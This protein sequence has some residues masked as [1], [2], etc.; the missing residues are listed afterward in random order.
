L[1]RDHA[2]RLG[3]RHRSQQHLRTATRATLAARTAATLPRD[4]LAR[5]PLGSQGTPAHA[6]IGL[7]HLDRVAE[8]PGDPARDLI[9]A[10]PPWMIVVGPGAKPSSARWIAASSAQVR[11]PQTSTLMTDASTTPD[12]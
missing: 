12:P 9:R 1:D 5:V 6:P 8:A 11:L 10:A 2:G 4:L 3:P 7:V